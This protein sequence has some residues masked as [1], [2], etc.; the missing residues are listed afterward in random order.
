VITLVVVVLDEGLDL[1]LEVTGQE[2]VFLQACGSSL[3]TA[4]WL[5]M[6]VRG[7]LMDVRR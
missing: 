1:D 4:P 6:N 7:L 5:S 2:V 3:V